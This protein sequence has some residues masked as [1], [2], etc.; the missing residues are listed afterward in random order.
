MWADHAIWWQVYPLGFTADTHTLAHLENW[1]DYAIELGCNGLLLGPVFASET[2]GYDTIDHFRIDP[3]LG[4]DA[5]FDRLV[6][7]AH[8]RGLRIALDGVFNHVARSFVHPEWFRGDGAT[9]EGHDQLIALDH[10]NPAVAQ[11][12]GDVVRYWL[13][14]GVDAWR[15]DAAYAVPPA[16]IRYGPLCPAGTG[17][18]APSRS[19]KVTVGMRSTVQVRAPRLVT[20]TRTTVGSSDCWARTVTALSAHVA[21]GAAAELLWGTA[22]SS[23]AAVVE[24]ARTGRIRMSGFPLCRSRTGAACTRRRLPSVTAGVYKGLCP[25]YRCYLPAPV[26]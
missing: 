22:R 25:T 7:K 8:D 2:H 6:A 16:P 18:A 4:D 26:L 17:R 15:L 10:S 9:F 5:D 21:G 11:Y 20:L 19:P 3:R 14:R 12:V 24:R 1:L 13:D 23:A